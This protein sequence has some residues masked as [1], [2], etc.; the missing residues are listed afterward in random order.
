MAHEIP[1]PDQD[2]SSEKIKISIR[3][4]VIRLNPTVKQSIALARAAGVARFTYN[5]A[6]AQWNSQF[7]ANQKP[8]AAKLKK[9]FNQIKGIEFPWIYESPK[10]ANQQPFT[11]LNVAFKNFFR[12]CKGERKGKK[13]GYPKFKKRGIHDSF[14]VS[15][16]KFSFRKRN[17]R[18]VVRLPKIGD[19]KTFEHLRFQ[20]KI[21]SGRVFRQAD[22]WFIS[23]NVQV[24]E[25][26][27]PHVFLNEIIGVDLG[28]KTAVVT[29]DGEM[30]DSPKPLKKNLKKLR[31]ANR[32]HS[33]RKKGSQN[34]KKAQAKLARLHQHIANI[35]QDFWHKLTTRLCRENQTVVIEDLRMAFMLR[36]RKLS[37]FESDVGLGKFRPMMLYKSEALSGNIIIADRF[38]PSTQRCSR[39]GNV[40]T[41]DDRVLLGEAWYNCSS[42]GT[43]EDRDLNAALNLLK[44]PGLL[45]NWGRKVLT[46]MDDLASTRSGFS[47]WAS[48]VLEVGTKPCSHLSTL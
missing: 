39:C 29:S 41:G 48:E 7:L 12:S 42:C 45:G 3:G 35:R 32:V 9:Q 14:Y 10:D 21:L 18:G 15:N 17:K 22:K 43:V 31:R 16:D 13:S 47:G 26:Q 37:R 24:S 40:K 30:I 1:T 36:N 20:G 38:F 34:R 46:P 6:L 28:L 8:S 33:R 23:V 5:W 4:H 2:N 11:D 19:V 27:E 44:Y 25:E